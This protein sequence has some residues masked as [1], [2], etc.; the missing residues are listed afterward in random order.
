MKQHSAAADLSPEDH[1]D[2][3]AIISAIHTIMD[4]G[5]A[6]LAIYRVLERVRQRAR[7]EREYSRHHEKVTR[8]TTATSQY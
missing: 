1:A 7:T 2:V 8:L 5:M 4:D 3:S 6:I